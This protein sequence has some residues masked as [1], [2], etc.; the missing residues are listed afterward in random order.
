M[1]VNHVLQDPSVVPRQGSLL[2]LAAL[3]RAPD[4]RRTRVVASTASVLSR[5]GQQNLVADYGLVARKPPRS[6]NASRAVSTS[7]APNFLLRRPSEY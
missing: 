3:K 7:G 1:T 4:R 6:A 2:D 5:A